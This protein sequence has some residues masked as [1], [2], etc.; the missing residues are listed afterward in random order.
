MFMESYL[1]R[2]IQMFDFRALHP[3]VWLGTAS[4][5]YTGWLG[6]IYTPE[7]Y[8]G[9]ITKRTKVVG[10]QTL[11]EEVLPIESVVEYF[12]H[13]RVL[14]LDFTFYRPLLDD[15]GRPTQNYHALHRYAQFLKDDNILILKVPQAVFSQKIMNKGQFVENATYLNPEVFTLQFYQPAQELLGDRIRGFVFEQEYQR[16]GNR[17]PSE[18]F[19]EDIERF[20]CR[21]PPDS[22]Y[23]IELRTESLFSPRLFDVMA[24]HGV[25]QVL[26]HWTWLP[27]LS[28]QFARSG[29]VLR[30][31][32]RDCIIRLLTPRGVRYE[33]A[34]VRAHPFTRL[35]DG[36][37]DT[38]MI[39]ET[40]RLMAAVLDQGGSANVIVNNR[41]GGNAPLIAQRIAQRFIEHTHG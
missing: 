1:A 29:Q 37:L 27:P 18:K 23:H 31:A 30:N 36:M 16:Q 35:V 38:R 25:G 15:H 34:Y 10:K 20:F 3:R 41:A 14:E 26:S 19:A 11:T 39:E 7:K 13:F 6:Q 5:R 8:Q 40:V 22:R 28:V 33:D 9:R 17:C 4:D 32:N 12:E 21:I 2:H 24:A